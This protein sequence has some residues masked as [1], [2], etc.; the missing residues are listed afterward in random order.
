[1]D[2]TALFKLTYGLYILTTATQDGRD[3]GCVV[4]AVMQLT[5]EPCIL[6]VCVNRNHLTNEMI[7]KSGV[8]NLSVLTEQVS[9]ELIAHFGYQSGRE[10]DKFQGVWSIEEEQNHSRVMRGKN[11][12]FYIAQD[13]NAYLECR[14]MDHYEYAT[15]TLFVA[16]VMEAEVFSE[17]ASITYT[18]YRNRRNH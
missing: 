7:K 10:A 2:K 13:T 15:H 12:I 6:S 5:D 8:F 16:E 4:D 9:Q 14:V 17:A 18:A 3:N 1:M 11:G